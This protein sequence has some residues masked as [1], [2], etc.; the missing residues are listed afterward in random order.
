MN[1]DD[2]KQGLLARL[3]GAGRSAWR[4]VRGN[5]ATEI[6]A[7][8]VPGVGTAMDVEDLAVGLSERDLPKAGLAAVGLVTPFAGA[9]LKGAGRGLRKIA[10]M[11]SGGGTLEGAM[12]PGVRNVLAAEIDPKAVE[13]LGQVVGRRVEP[14]DVM[15]LDPAE[16]ARM[17]PD[18]LHAS[19]VCTRFSC[20]NKT[21]GEIALDVESAQAVA[22]AIEEA[23]PRAVSIENV[24]RYMES[25]SYRDIIR[26]ALER[27]GY[28]FD[29]GVYD[30]ADFG[31]MQS[32][33]RMITRAVREG[34]LPDIPERSG[35][36]DWYE[37][38]KDLIAGAP[39]SEIPRWERER[40]QSMIERGTLDPDSPIITMGG[41]AGGGVAYARNAGG[42]AP[43]LK[44][45]REVPRIMLPGEA[46]R[47]VTPEMMRRMMGL[48]DDYPL[49]GNFYDAKSILGK[50]MEGNITRA[51]IEPLMR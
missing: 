43:T 48:G 45:G 42:P 38:L 47:R 34:D 8:L 41:S 29:E 37:G 25:E 23:N 40:I 33:K 12:S 3:L 28:N 16:I 44:A 4:D 30:A 32:R 21:P 35:P 24:P 27:A 46:S 10:S 49:P 15:R 13:Q 51:L 31:G 5:M 2:D 50:G 17:D 22:R 6:G 1:E 11:F 18:L 7:S 19:P 20:A 26:P 36:T 39:E 14:L 9:Q